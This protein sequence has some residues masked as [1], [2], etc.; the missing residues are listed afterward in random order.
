MKLNAPKDKQE[1]KELLEKAARC[2]LDNQ[3]DI[4]CF[5]PQSGETE[6]NLAHHYANEISKLLPEFHTDLEITKTPQY[7]SEGRKRPDIVFHKRG[8]HDKNILVIELKLMRR[9]QSVKKFDSH[10]AEK[11]EKYW[12]KEDFCYT[13]GAQVNFKEGDTSKYNVRVLDNPEKLGK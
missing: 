9:G 2:L 3:P 12:F 6:W 7:D 10:D 5:T 8:V 13:F 4:Y 1:V 11:I